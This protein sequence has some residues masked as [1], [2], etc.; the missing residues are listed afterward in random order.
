MAML[1]NQRVYIIHFSDEN[2]RRANPP[3][4]G[5]PDDRALEDGD[6]LNVD[7]T[8]R[9]LGRFSVSFWVVNS[10]DFLG[11]MVISKE[12]WRFP[13]ENGDFQGK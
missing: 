5:I 9:R 8:A 6:I 3:R 10:G 4:H 1:N 12:T 2:G 13:R 11:K 7:V